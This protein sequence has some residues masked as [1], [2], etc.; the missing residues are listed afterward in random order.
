MLHRDT[1]GPRPHLRTR[2]YPSIMLF[3]ILALL[4]VDFPVSIQV[5]PQTATVHAQTLLGDFGDIWA[6]I[7]LDDSHDLAWG[8]MDNDGDL[9]LA[10]ANRGDVPGR[11]YRNDNGELESFWESP[12][13]YKSQALPG[14]TTTTTVIWT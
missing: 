13:S 11:I 10:V 6:S 7:E 1:A 14:A 9:D 8:D 4:F 12:H 3:M 5:L 2:F